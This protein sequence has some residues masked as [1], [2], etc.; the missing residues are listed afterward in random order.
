M[1][2]S[3][4][5]N[6]HGNAPNLKPQKIQ[7]CLG[8][9]K[10]LGWENWNQSYQTLDI[11]ELYFSLLLDDKR[12]V[13]TYMHKGGNGGGRH[14]IFTGKVCGAE[15]VRAARLTQFRLN[16]Q[17]LAYY[18]N[19]WYLSNKLKILFKKV[20]CFKLFVSNILFMF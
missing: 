3:L 20:N 1:K 17:K 15:Y 14:R 6:F 4:E 8:F 19:N 5:Q 9:L 16:K 10:S 7:G 18:K 2:W 13:I 11:G 12:H